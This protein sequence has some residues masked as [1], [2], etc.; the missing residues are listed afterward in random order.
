MPQ[1]SL[2]F[3]STAELTTEEGGLMNMVAKNFQL[4]WYGR[5]KIFEGRKQNL[6]ELQRILESR[7]WS[8]LHCDFLDRVAVEHHGSW[9]SLETL[10]DSISRKLTS[11]TLKDPTPQE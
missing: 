5:E 1:H 11:P 3:T 2:G 7:L 10:M 4:E 8:A 9:E 6:L